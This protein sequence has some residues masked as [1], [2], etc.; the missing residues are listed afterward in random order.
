MP[1]V[2]CAKCGARNRVDERRRHLRA[3][4]GRCGADLDGPAGE[5]APVDVTDATF[6]E[7]VLGAG[8]RPVL[9]DCWAEWCGPCRMIAPVL[10]SLAAAAGGRYLV[11]KLNIDENPRVAQELGIRS[12]PTLLIFKNGALVDRMLGV[13]SR[14]DIEAKLSAHL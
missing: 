3:V 1:I 9:V 12:I 4:C 11:A 14:R 7:R 6:A 10:D 5:A 8:P 13:H 2:T